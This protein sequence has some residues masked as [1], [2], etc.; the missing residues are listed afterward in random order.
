LGNFWTASERI[1]IFSEVYTMGDETNNQGSPQPR[2]RTG[3]PGSSASDPSS[4]NA[5]DKPSGRGGK[6]GK[7]YQIDIFRDWCKNCG[8]C[9]AFCPK[10]CIRMSEEGVPEIVEGAQCSGCGWCEV[11]CPDFAISVR[12]FKPKKNSMDDECP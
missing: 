7:K 12:E 3:P 1:L 6:A 8:I 10:G 4:R 5:P 2:E 11:H 9:S